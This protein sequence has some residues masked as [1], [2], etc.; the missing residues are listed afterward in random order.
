MGTDLPGKTDGNERERLIPLVAASALM[1]KLTGGG[2][3]HA[4]R[5][6]ASTTAK[7]TKNAR[8]RIDIGIPQDIF[9]KVSQMRIAVQKN[10]LQ[11]TCC[12]RR[13]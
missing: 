10:T 13:T 3:T 4:V 9:A 2:A 11:T 6:T 1:G 7:V 8:P 12:A 5:N